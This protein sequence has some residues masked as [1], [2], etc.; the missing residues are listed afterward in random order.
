MAFQNPEIIKLLGE[1]GNAIK[2]EKWAKQREIEGKINK[3]KNGDGGKTLEK[4][5]TP[6]SVFMTFESEEGVNRALKFDE[7]TN[8]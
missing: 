2:G 5:T 3:L 1:R 4:L 8:E 6:V 7:T